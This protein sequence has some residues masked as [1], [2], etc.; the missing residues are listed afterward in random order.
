MLGPGIFWQVLALGVYSISIVRLST[1]FILAS[2]GWPSQQK[3]PGR[4]TLTT[5]TKHANSSI[6]KDY[7]N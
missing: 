4:F 2:G 6:P 3:Q 5:L 1:I 7:A